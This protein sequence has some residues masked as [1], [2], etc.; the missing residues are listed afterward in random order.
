[1]ATT[2][3]PSASNLNNA[4]LSNGNLTATGGASQGSNG[5]GVATASAASGQKRFWSVKIV[6]AGQSV[7]VAIGNTAYVGAIQ[8]NV[9][10]GYDTRGI[11]YFNDGSVVTNN[12]AVTSIATFN[13]GDVVD[14][15][16]DVA[17]QRV[18]FRVNGGSWNNSGTADPA[19]NTGGISI[20]GLGAAP[21]YPAFVVMYDWG[22]IRSSQ[23]ANFGATALP[24]A[25]PTGFTAFDA[26]AGGRTGTL[27]RTLGALTSA[28]AGKIRVGGK[29][30]KTLGVLTVSAAG[31]L[32]IGGKVVRT[33]GALTSSAAGK[34]RV[35]GGT[36]RTLGNL[37]LAATGTGA[38][39][40]SGTLAKT[41]GALTGAAAGKV[42]VAGAGMAGLGA[43]ASAVIGKV[44]VKGTLART[45]DS[46]TLASSQSES[47]EVAPVAVPGVVYAYGAPPLPFGSIDWP[48][49]FGFLLYAGVDPLNLGAHE[50]KAYLL[51]GTPFDPVGASRMPSPPLP[52]GEI[53][54][55]SPFDLSWQGAAPRI[56]PAATI[57]RSSRPEDTPANTYVPAKFDL[58][59]FNYSMELFG[60]ADPTSAG[61]NTVG[62]LNISD[63]DAE[64]DGLLRLGWDG[65]PLQILRGDPDDLFA[66]W[67]VV[68]NVTAAGI[69][70]DTRQK[71]IQLRDL[72]RLL[73]AAPLHD[74]RYDGTG[75]LDGDAEIAGKVKP[76]AVGP[77]FNVT[78]VLM[79]AAD[80]IYQV[81]CTPVQS[82]VAKDGGNALTY[83]GDNPDFATLQAAVIA[84]GHY[85]TCLALGLYRMGG[86]PLLIATADLVG[87]N[88]SLYGH[89]RPVTRGQIARRIVTG[90]GSVRLDDIDDLDG[91]AFLAMD[92]K[93]PAPCGFYWD[94]ETTKGA[95]LSRVMA[96]CLGFWF[97]RWNGTLA[98][99]QAE[100]PAAMTPYLSLSFPGPRAADVRVGE[101]EMT[102]Y[103]VPRRQ[104][105][106]G[107]RR[108][109]T[110]LQT[111]QVAGVLD[112]TSS[113][114][115]QQ[116]T[117][118]ASSRDAW[119]S[120]VYPTGP[121]VEV[122]DSGFVFQ[123]DAQLEADR[124]QGLM[125]TGRERFSLPAVLDPLGDYAGRPIRLTNVNRM[126]MGAAKNL[127]CVGMNAQGP[128]VKLE[129]WG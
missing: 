37:T 93:Q 4:A 88:E 83:D 128:Q 71:E 103:K 68:A 79:V 75:G 118:F 122:P 81:S 13:D 53:D 59:G 58:A 80:L 31:N 112:L 127:L 78:P 41:L 108:N 45:L 97:V 23:T 29:T 18:W 22:G 8:Y 117:Q 87:D 48:V 98:I 90:R 32:R 20:S 77:S 16:L 99:G 116:E 96:G 82:I 9:W 49:P 104:T 91:A 89:G 67:S 6:K 70:N 61:S 12:A 111:N 74:Q 123:A 105:L 14:V 34:V 55:P 54:W 1:M 73:N 43:L 44:R 113:A 109:Y 62:V 110:V 38:D 30:A 72:G 42:R 66:N 94:S 69:L 124:A 126:G 17:A 115:L 64:L 101:P 57:G 46:L 28:G 56:W 25:A 15:A 26:S 52:F 121:I 106:I 19:T 92:F 107:Y 5:S 27:A 65:A 125:S 21:Y 36:A 7:G 11:C 120:S 114:A 76:Y 63:P 35:S 2:W 3:D 129:L 86:K 24:Y 50:G 39:A 85:R 40:V 119:N 33:L 51:T 60:G 95:A 47:E 84:A 10:P 102:D 100:D